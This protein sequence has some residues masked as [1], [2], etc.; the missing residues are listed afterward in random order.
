MSELS[1]ET[2]SQCTGGKVGKYKILD[3]GRY[4]ECFKHTHS[5]MEDWTRYD[6]NGIVSMYDTVLYYKVLSCIMKYLK[7]C[8]CELKQI[9]LNSVSS[10][11]FK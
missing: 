4:T 7:N 8:D 1:S 3:I 5:R 6:K 11:Q 10:K 9:T 2:G